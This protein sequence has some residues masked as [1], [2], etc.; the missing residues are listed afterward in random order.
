MQLVLTLPKKSHLPVYIQ[1]ADA[2]K[3]SI[4]RG[5]LR[6]GDRLPSIRELSSSLKLARQTIN[7]AYEHLSSQN[8]INIVHGSG[9]YVLES[10]ERAA[11]ADNNTD[12]KLEDLPA[13]EGEIDSQQQ[14]I[15]LSPWAERL[16]MSDIL[17]SSTPDIS[18]EL[19]YNAALL[20]VLPLNLWKKALYKSSSMEDLSMLS[21]TADP[22]GYRPLRE[23]IAQYLGRARQLV[24]SPEQVVVFANT[25]AGTDKLARVLLQPGDLVAV[26]EPGSPGV[27]TT[28]FTHQARLMPLQVDQDGIV[29]N[30]LVTSKET[31]RLMYITPSH[32]DPTGAPMSLARRE[33]LL[34]WAKDK[35][36]L[37]IEDDY[38][39]EYYY[40]QRTLPAL[41]S[42]DK[43]QRVIYRCNF[44]KSL[45]PLV[46]IGFLVLPKPLVPVIARAKMLTE[47]DVSFL[48]QKALA[49]FI[50][51]GY[52]ERHLSRTLTVYESRRAAVLHA[53]A[54]FCKKDV[55]ASS[56]TAGTHL[57]AHF[58]PD[59][60]EEQI[61]A[62]ARSSGVPLI[63]TKQH[64]A[65][66]PKSNEFI[67][68][69]AT[70][71]GEAI[72]D[73][74]RMFADLL[75]QT[76]STGAPPAPPHS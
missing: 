44:W 49:E 36:C 27:R 8:Y 19:N 75:K 61:I 13:A 66:T 74:F 69:F 7:R 15:T 71:S 64:Y 39:C 33:M 21:Y 52:F 3:F 9:T 12:A 30:Q 43:N 18:V 24:C 73:I 41:M 32:H 4:N 6:P 38:D 1:V 68:A 57:L 72:D 62:C 22:L 70:L 28:F 31:P 5:T 65:G 60:S 54:R 63:S 59:L 11:P 67:I 58:S 14:H 17:A 47:R 45:F 46:K 2:I 40:G 51:L 35:D 10:P 23:A 53:I 16:M 48:E 50:T 42:M 55:T 25:E 37:I 34:D 29:V 26:E 20:E 56:T 76:R